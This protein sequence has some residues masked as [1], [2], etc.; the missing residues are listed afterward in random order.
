[1]MQDPIGY[2][3]ELQQRRTE[4]MIKKEKRHKQNA[5]VTSTGSKSS[6]RRVHSVANQKRLKLIAMSAIDPSDSSSLEHSSKQKKK[7]N[8]SVSEDNFGA[9]DDDWNIYLTMVFFCSIYVT[10][11]A[12]EPDPES[13]EENL[14]ISKI[15]SILEKYSSMSSSA[16]QASIDSNK[17]L[18]AEDYQIYLTVERIRVPEI[19]FQPSIIGIDQMGIPECLSHIFPLFS[20]Q[21]QMD[22]A[23]VILS[24]LHLIAQNV[25]TT[26]GNTKFEGFGAR[27]E[28]ELR[29]IRPANSVVK[30]FSA[31]DAI[32]DS[33]RGGK[34]FSSLPEFSSNS[35]SYSDYQ[36]MGPYYFKEHFASNKYFVLS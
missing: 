29:A 14:E 35:I 20:V 5:Q 22:L 8:S 31:S 33:W 15:D 24:H 12:N 27:I 2:I 32:L 23:Q 17:K 25:F 10:T 19:I 36:E 34:L 13:E 26:G 21:D 9:N 7:S 28:K 3:N 30:V 4:V 1:M 16:S 11:K 18:T 6:G